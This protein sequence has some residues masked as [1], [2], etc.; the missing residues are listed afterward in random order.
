METH[1]GGETHHW[2]NEWRET[3]M[4][5]RDSEIVRERERERKRTIYKLI[6]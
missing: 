4:K 5:E 3:R 6:V 1:K 2:E